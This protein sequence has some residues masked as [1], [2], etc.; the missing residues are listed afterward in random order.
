L[1]Y[2]LAIAIQSNWIVS[3]AGPFPASKSDITIYRYGG[4]DKNNPAPALRDKITDG[5]RAIGDS[6][7]APEDGKTMSI[8][9][10]GDSGEIAEFKARAKS[11]HETFNSRIKAFAIL[12]TE[13]R[14]DIKYHQMAMESVCIIVQYD[15][16]S[17]HG[18]FAV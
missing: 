18:L 11:R 2:E 12:A 10:T 15:L 8:S 7:Y 5:K 3:I 4:G 9:R 17:G 16:E 6:I 1:T 13:F 14:H